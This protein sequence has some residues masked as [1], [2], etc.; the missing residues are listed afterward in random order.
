MLRTGQLALPRTCLDPPWRKSLT[1]Q[2]YK[3]GLGRR[4]HA[5]VQCHR[6]PLVYNTAAT[7][8]TLYATVCHCMPLYVP[9]YATTCHY[10][11][12]TCH[13]MTL[14]ATV[15]HTEYSTTSCNRPN[16]QTNTGRIQYK[17]CPPP[18]RLPSSR[19]PDRRRAGY[20]TPGAAGGSGAA[21]PL[22]EGGVLEGGRWRRSNQPWRGYASAREW[23]TAA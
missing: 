2:G 5:Q 18:D 12:S 23:T 3:L 1:P 13:N 11:A 22:L 8:M 14:Y 19:P 9:L 16:R 17:H 7:S 20:P 21:G 4:A 15:R 10:C 6:M